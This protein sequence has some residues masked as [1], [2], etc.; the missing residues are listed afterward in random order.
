MERALPFTESQLTIRQL[1][2]KQFSVIF[3][4][5]LLMD[6][7]FSWMII[8]NSIIIEAYVKLMQIGIYVFL[9]LAFRY[10]SAG[11]KVVIV[12]FTLIMARLVVESVLKYD[13]LF[14]QLTMF[15]V[16]FP[17]LYVVFTK[18]L[19][20]RLQKDVLPLTAAFYFGSYFIFML[21]FG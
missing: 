3:F 4:C 7:M 8:R 21:L 10:L 20:G 5:F 13:S 15:L 11:E 9:L 18:Y 16:L 6:G 2:I 17:V 1:N 12:I 14:E 19:L